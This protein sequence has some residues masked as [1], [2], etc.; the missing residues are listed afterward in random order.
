ME[1]IIKFIDANGKMFKKENIKQAYKTYII[2]LVLI[3]CLSPFVGGLIGALGLTIIPLYC[4]AACVYDRNILKT[5]SSFVEILL[6]YFLLFGY[7]LIFS[8]FLLY[9]LP[10]LMKLEFDMFIMLMI[11]FE[12]VSIVLGC[13]YTYVSIKRNKIKERKQTSVLTTSII[14]TLSCCYVIFLR[15]YVS[16]MPIETQAFIIL[17]PIIICC[18]GFAFYIGEVYIPMLYFIKKYNITGMI[19]HDGAS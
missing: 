1:N 13:I 7:F 12:I 18:C 17:L 6:S 15:R 14:S 19:R 5:P 9:S 3:L 2:L 8:N 10:K 11:V 16:T 4:I